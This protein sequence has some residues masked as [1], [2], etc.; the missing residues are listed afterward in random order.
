MLRAKTLALG[1][2]GDEEKAHGVYFFRCKV[3]SWSKK[4][5]E[6]LLQEKTNA[7]EVVPAS[8]T[9]QACSKFGSCPF[10]VRARGPVEPWARVG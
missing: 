8:G 7:V 10:L 4:S 9:S 6:K 5:N 3:S 2:A 1:E